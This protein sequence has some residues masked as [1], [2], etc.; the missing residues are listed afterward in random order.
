VPVLFLI[1]I[2]SALAAV[3]LHVSLGQQ[4]TVTVALQESR[5]LAAARAGIEWMNYTVQPTLGNGSCTSGTLHLS[6]GALNGFT[7][8]VTCTSASFTDG[9]GT[10]QSYNIASTASSGTYGT[11]DFVQRT[12]QATFTSEP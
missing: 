5:A 12:V 7:V 2:V 9:N 11:S 10:F 8:T 4:Q 6:E 3:A 1:V